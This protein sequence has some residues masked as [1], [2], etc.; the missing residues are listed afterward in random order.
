M[1]DRLALAPRLAA[2]N[3]ELTKQAPGVKACQLTQAFRSSAEFQKLFFAIWTGESSDT[4]FAVSQ[5]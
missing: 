5:T 2:T 4:I 1:H 3:A